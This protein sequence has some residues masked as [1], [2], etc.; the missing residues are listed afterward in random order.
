MFF[1]LNTQ[2][3]DLL[4]KNEC[5]YMSCMCIEIESYEKLLVGI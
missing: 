3:D 4:H 2:Y 1:Y 5:E